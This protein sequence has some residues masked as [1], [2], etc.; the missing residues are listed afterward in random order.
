MQFLVFSDSHGNVANMSLAIRRNP[1]I[2]TVLFLGDGLGDVKELADLHPT[3]DFRAV[4]GNCDAFSS[5][6]PLEATLTL[7]GTTV[8]Y[9][10][11][12]LYGVK[13][14]LGP[15]VSRAKE[16]G[17]SVLLFGHTHL[18]FSEYRSDEEMYVFN[19]GS[20]GRA[21]DGTPSFGILDILPDGSVSLS[22]GK[23][24]SKRP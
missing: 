19:P 5:D 13:T 18:P 14:V 9:C 22:H 17:A 10:H 24:T 1:T 23:L 21:W 16:A 15:A 6:A 20:I 4:R 7:Y 2:K 12:H 3:I 11:G 8:Y